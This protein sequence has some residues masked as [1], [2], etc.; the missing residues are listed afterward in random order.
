MTSG[1]LPFLPF[2]LPELGEEEIAEVVDTLRSGWITTGPKARRFEQD[3]VAFLDAMPAPPNAATGRPPLEAIAVNSATAGLHLA[4]EALGIGPGDEVITTTH[5]FTATAEVVRYLGAD[6]VLVDIDPATLNIDPVLV[7]AA[8]T[9]RTK[10]II[11]VHFAGLAAPMDAILDIARRYGLKVVEDAAHAL[12]TTCQGQAIG[13]MASDATVFSFYANK[14][15]TTGEG[16]MVVTRDPQIAQRIKVMRLH[17]ISRDAFDRFTA[18]TPS[19]Y[20][21]IVAPG[22]KYNLTDIA[23]ALGIHQLKRVSGF[24]QRRAEIARRFHE[25][26]ADLPLVLPPGPARGDLHAWHL[27]VVRLADG[28]PID[29]NTFIQQLFALGIGVSVHY[30]PLHLHPYWRERYALTA[31]Q[32]PHSQHAYER[33]A[34]LPL[35]TKMS[36]AD[37]ERVIGAVRQV[38]RG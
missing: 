35:Y 2:A 13:T 25:A 18:K 15:I 38:L 20:Y 17:G 23:A 30:I 3:F 27:Y 8:I 12:P 21:E 32:F 37:V 11:P 29:R 22:F 31:A 4:L 33:M 16:G 19:W 36:E 5:T 34:S 10:A 28:A 9:P 6:V 24:Q 1:E 7:E 26:F 14:T